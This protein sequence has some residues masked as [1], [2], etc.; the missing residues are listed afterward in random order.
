MLELLWL[1]LAKEDVKVAR[2]S[3]PFEVQVLFWDNLE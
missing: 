3:T 1:P 2:A